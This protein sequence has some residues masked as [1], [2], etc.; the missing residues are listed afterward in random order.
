MPTLMRV[1]VLPLGSYS[2]LLDMDWLYLHRTR[3]DCYDK[4]IECLDDNG[5]KRKLQGKTKP[6]SVR[7][8]TVMQAKHN[9]RKGCI[10]FVVHI[11]NDKGKDIEDAKIFERYNIL[12]HFQDVF[13]T[14]ISDFPPHREVEFSI[15]LVQGETP[16]LKTPY[17]MSTPNLVELKL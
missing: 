11:S 17:K 3:V 9:H 8:I 6:T 15:E 7:M 14:N 10:L 13:P 5:E 2:I 12:H 16:P 1:N 4:I